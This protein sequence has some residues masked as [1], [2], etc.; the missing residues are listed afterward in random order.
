[1]GQFMRKSCNKRNDSIQYTRADVN[2]RPMH[3]RKVSALDEHQHQRKA[4]NLNR[5]S[6]NKT[7]IRM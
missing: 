5:F 7:L 4:M 2:A 3:E 1:M 6:S